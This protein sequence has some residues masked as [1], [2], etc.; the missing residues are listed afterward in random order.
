MRKRVL[1]CT[2][3]LMSVSIPASAQVTSCGWEM[4]R[5]VCRPAGPQPAPDIVGNAQRAGR[6]ASEQMDRLFEMRHA[7]EMEQAELRQA[8]RSA[9]FNAEKHD[10][11][12]NEMIARY[13]AIGRCAEAEQLARD[14]LGNIDAKRSKARCVPR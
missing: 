4:G 7:R 11:E 13:E 3:A 12:V 8:Q 1:L 10:L 9:V 14:E 5:W 2:L 6:E